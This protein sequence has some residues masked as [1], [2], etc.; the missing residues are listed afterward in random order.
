MVCD[1]IKV[2]AFRC[3]GGL[4]RHLFDASSSPCVNSTNISVAVYTTNLLGDGPASEPVSIELYH[5]NNNIIIIVILLYIKI[6][7]STGGGESSSCE[8]LKLDLDTSLFIGIGA[9]MIT[10]LV[11]SLSIIIMVVLIRS[12]AKLQ[13]ELETLTAGNTKVIYEEVNNHLSPSPTLNT[14]ENTAYGVCI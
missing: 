6:L 11:T 7:F 13:K 5:R 12:K 8:Y 1:S 4:C 9:G 3:Q 14:R 10:L 2:P